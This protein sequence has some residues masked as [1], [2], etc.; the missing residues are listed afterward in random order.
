MKVKKDF[1]EWT[2]TDS[3][4]THDLSKGTTDVLAELVVLINKRVVDVQQEIV[5]WNGLNVIPSSAAQNVLGES[6]TL[7]NWNKMTAE[8]QDYLGQKKNKQ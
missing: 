5:R 6:A 1:S 4:E 3:F 2:Q 8:E 7:K